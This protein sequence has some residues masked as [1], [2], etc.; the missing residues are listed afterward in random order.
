MPSPRHLITAHVFLSPDKFVVV[1]LFVLDFFE[2]LLNLFDER[3]LTRF[4]LLLL[5]PQTRGQTRKAL[6]PESARRQGG[7]R[8]GDKTTDRHYN[9]CFLSLSL[10]LPTKLV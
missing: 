8:T 2:W 10:S 4:L 3:F 7:L 9:A 5:F 1:N 6:H